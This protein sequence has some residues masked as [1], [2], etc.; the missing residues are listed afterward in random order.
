MIKL[1]ATDLDGTL[2]NA[3]HRSDDMI[4]NTILRVTQSDK[5]FAIVTGRHMH[6]N[7]RIG[8][9][10]FKNSFYQIYLN[11]AITLDKAN[12]VIDR[13]V[14]DKDFVTK[15]C[16]Q[17]KHLPIELVNEDGV[18]T[19][20]NKH[21]HF[22]KQLQQ[23]TSFK[24]FITVLVAYLKAPFKLRDEHIVE[25][26][27][28][29]VIRVKDKN[30]QEKL[31]QYL[32]QQDGIHVIRVHQSLFEIIKSG[33][34][35]Q[36]A[37]VNLLRTLHIQDEE[38]AVYGNDINDIEMMTYFENAYAPNDALPVIQEVSHVLPSGVSDHAVAQ[39][40]NQLLD[41]Q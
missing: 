40:I 12:H 13:Q 23:T 9:T 34:N 2:L 1:I 41:G 19:Q 32:K 25:N 33:V 27:A 14:L 6:A 11:G 18:Y 26:S 22:L 16:E 36:T 39:H 28:A 10:F 24:L 21:K 31:A 15:T 3:L 30:E 38:V 5:E 7:H 17:F 35:K 29:M 4:D 37:L 20:F 8:L